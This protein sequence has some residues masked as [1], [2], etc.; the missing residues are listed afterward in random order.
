M[1]TG[2]VKDKSY[3]EYTELFHF[4]P[5]ILVSVRWPVLTVTTEWLQLRWIKKP[6]LLHRH[7]ESASAKAG[8]ARNTMCFLPMI[9]LTSKGMSP[10]CN[11]TMDKHGLFLPSMKTFYNGNRKFTIP[12]PK[13]FKEGWNLHCET[14]RARFLSPCLLYKVAIVIINF[15]R[16]GGSHN[17]FTR[18][19]QYFNEK[20]STR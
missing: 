2:N 3:G 10:V 14:C 9:A 11:S 12:S 1:R 5:L 8:E 4:M 16:G 19:V 13:C 18:F 17:K 7:E 20:I 15:A 6:S